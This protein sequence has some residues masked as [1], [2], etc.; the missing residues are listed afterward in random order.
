[1]A[2]WLVFATWRPDDAA[3]HNSHWMARQTI[4]LATEPPLVIE[5]E[6]AVRE[7]LENALA[8]GGIRGVALFGHGHKS[9]VIGSDGRDALDVGN[10]PLASARWIHA[11]AC[12]T[13]LELGPASASHVDVFV[14]YRIPLIVE[15]DIEA[16]SP[17]LKERLAR[18][19]TATTLALLE[20]IRTKQE[21]QQRASAVADDI[22]AWLLE[23]SSDS[24]HLGLHVLAETLVDRMVTSRPSEVPAP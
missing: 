12:L 7:A 8:D 2:S 17:E 20:G 15:W 23:N 13:G 21:L 9:G 6:A 11:V 18:L 24:A 14:G 22:A 19:V 3:L 10:I 5:R 16:L 1:M 4:R